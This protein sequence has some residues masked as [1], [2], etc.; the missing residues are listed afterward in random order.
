[1]WGDAIIGFGSQHYQYASG[2]EGDMP[3][4]GFSPR[5]QNLTLYFQNGIQNQADALARLGK[6]KLGGGC[7]YIKKLSDVNLAVL[8]EMLAAQASR[9]A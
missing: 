2:R 1:M 8:K 5:K 4:V 3:L 7:L 6:H 9:F